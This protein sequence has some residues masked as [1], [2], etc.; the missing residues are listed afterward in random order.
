MNRYR[1]PIVAAVVVVFLAIGAF[2]IFA[3]QTKGGA[4]VTINATVSKGTSMSPGTWTAHHNDIVTVNI[5]SDMDGEVHL[6]GYDIPFETKAGQVVTKTFTA[7]KTGDFPI[8]WESTSTPLGH[9][10]VS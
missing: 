5:T 10:V 8:E 4:K 1:V 2:L 3:N 6:H 7:D 9:L